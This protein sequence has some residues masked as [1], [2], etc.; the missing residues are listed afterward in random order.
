[1]ST[2]A[3]LRTAT[4]TTN[5]GDVI[6]PVG[7]EAWEVLSVTAVFVTTATV[8]NRV[9]RLEFLDAAP[10]LKATFGAGAN[11]TASLTTTVC[12]GPDVPRDAAIAAGTLCV[13]MANAVVL[14]GER[15]RVRDSADVDAADTIDVRITFRPQA[16]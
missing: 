8:G 3:A 13:P 7:G 4:F 1:M 5:T 6:I 9:A 12:W 15:L 16:A 11:I 2:R 14:P 10:A